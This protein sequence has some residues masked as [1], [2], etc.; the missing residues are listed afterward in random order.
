MKIQTTV[1]RPLCNK[2]GNKV[3]L[4]TKDSPKISIVIPTYNR[5][6]YLSQAIKSALDQR[7]VYSN[8]E[9]LVID[10]GST[11]NTKNIVQNFQNKR[12]RYIYKEHS[13]CPNTR[14]FA[15]NNAYGDYILWLDSDD[16]ILPGIL[17][18]YVQFV[19]SFPEVDIFYPDLYITDANL[20]I[21]KELKYQD[22]YNRNDEL[23]AKLLFG[24]HVPNGG[25]IIKK[26]L[27]ERIGNFDESFVRAHDY[28]FY[29]RAVG[30]AKF[31]KFDQFVYKWRW[32]DSNMSS[33]TVNYDTVYEALVSVNM[34][35]IYE[36]KLL[37]PTLP[38]GNK[39]MKECHSEAYYQVALRLLRL[40]Q[41]V[42]SL[43]Y[44]EKSLELNKSPKSVLLREKLNNMFPVEQ[45]DR[46]YFTVIIPTFNR[47]KTLHSSIQSVLDQN[48]PNFEII[49]V[50]D[51]GKDVQPIIDSFKRNKQITYIS[52]EINKGISAARNTGI[53]AARGEYI[54]LLDDDD[55]FYPEHLKTA[56]RHL[57]KQTPVIYT[58]A[59]RAVQKKINGNYKII[60]QSIPYSIE[61]DRHKLLIGN[62]APVN[63]F[64][65]NRMLALKAGLFDTS[66][67]SLEDWEFWI[68]LSH[69]CDFKH[70][71]VPTVQVNWRTDGTTITSSLNNSF[72][73]NRRILYNRY[74]NIIKR[75][76]N[77][78]GIL[79]EFNKI[80][81]N[82]PIATSNGEKGLVSIVILTFNQLRYTK[83]CIRSIQKYTSEKHEI[84]FVDNGSTDGTVKW[85]RSQSKK[86]SNYKL[87]LNDTNNGF[88]KGCN[89]GIRASTG[90]YILLLNN[91]VVVTENW[92]SGMIEC[93]NFR[94]DVGIV[95]PMTNN[96][97]GPQKVP[98]VSY[99]SIQDLP[100]FA[101]SFNERNRYRR[102][103]HQRIVG[104]CMLF[105]RKLVDDI[106]YLDESFGTGNFEDD[107]FCL[108]S[109]LHGYQNYIAGDVFIHHYGSRSFIGNKIEYSGLLDSNKNIFLDKWN[110][111][112]RNDPMFRN[113]YI[114]NT[115]QKANE[116][117]HKGLLDKCI[118]LLLDGLK[119]FADSKEIAYHLINFLKENNRFEEACNLIEALPDKNSDP[120][121]YILKGY[122]LEGLE[123][124]NEAGAIAERLSSIENF[125]PQALNLKGIMAYK[126]GDHKAA[127]LLFNE[128]IA[129][130][131]SYDEPYAN[132]G[133]L[134]WESGKHDD[135]LSLFERS[136]ILSPTTSNNATN[137]HTAA[138]ACGAIDSA[139]N[140]F[141]EANALFPISK[142][143]KFLHIDLLV[144]TGQFARAMDEIESSML[145]F[146]IDDG[147]LKAGLEIRRKIGPHFITKKLNVKTSISLC[148]IVKN[149]EHY[150]ARCL[151]NLKPL[152]DELIVVDTGSDDSTRDIAE[153]FGAK[154]FDYEWQD[155]FAAARNF[156]LKKASGG[157]IL[158]MD[159][160]EVIAASDH[161][162]ILDLIKKSKNNK[163]AYVLT[164][165]NYTD[166]QDSAG[167]SENT[168][169]YKEEMS[170]GWIPS[171]KVR[172]FQNQKG[173][174][175]VFP[176]HEQVDPVLSDMGISLVESPIPV[177]HYGKL[178]QA[179]T[180]ER[181]QTYYDIG[182][183]KLASQPDNDHALKEL[184]IQAGLLS[185]WE[186]AATLW[187]SFIDRNP[188]SVDGYLNI[189]RVMANCGDY[190]QANRYA[191]KA[192]QIAGD[193]SE[194]IYN[195]VLSE[196]Q[197]GQAAKAAK[198]ANRM[199]GTFPDDPD[200]KL[201]YALAEICA[202]KI[203][204]GTK[205]LCKLSEIVP[206]A[207]L[208]PR[209]RS[210]LGSIK[211]AGFD[212][213]VISL[214]AELSKM[215]HFKDMA[216]QSKTPLVNKAG[217]TKKTTLASDENTSILFEKAVR[218]YEREN[219]QAAIDSIMNI[220]AAESDHWRSYELLVDVM[221]Q[222]DQGIDIPNQLRA[223]ENRS[224]L[225]ARMMALIGQGYEVSG[226]LEKATDFAAQALNIDAECAR[227]W[228]LKGVI[229][230]R[231]GHDSEASQ[232][233]Q[234]ASECDKNW[235]DPWTNMGTLHWDHRDQDKALD[236]FETGFQ[237]SPTGPNVATTYHI[238]ISETGQYERAR[239]LFEQAI[240]HH[241]NFRKGRFLLID[242][243]IRMEAYQEA[244]DHI[245]TVLVQF[246]ADPQFL[247]A[248]KT[249]RDKVGPMTVEKGKQPSLSVCMIVKNEEKYLPGCL[250]S[251]KPIADEMIIIDTGSEDATRDIAEIFGAR[252]FDYEWQ[253]DFSAA[254]NHSLK[255][256][257]GDWI[258][259]MDADE[260][261]APS[262]HEILRSLI[263]KH[264]DENI[265]FLMTARNYTSI[266]NGVGWFANDGAY[267]AFET[268]C[269]W[270]PSTKTRLFKRSPQIR[271]EYPVH[272]LV[273]PSLD[274]TG[275][276]IT[277]CDVPVHHY[278]CLH[279]AHASKKSLQYNAIAQD[280]LTEMDNDPKVLKELAIRASILGEYEEAID[281]WH[282]LARIQPKNPNVHINLSAIYDKLGRFREAKLAAR[283]ATMVAPK[284]KEGYLNLGRSELLLGNYTAA[285]KAFKKILSM[286]KSFHSAI[287]LLGSAQIC[288]GKA[289]V[290][291]TTISQLRKMAI[292]H[293]LP[294]AF[295]ELATNLANA[296]FSIKAQ[297][298]TDCVA[299]L[300]DDVSPID[301]FQ[302]EGNESSV[303][304]PNV[305][306]K[307]S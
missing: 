258:L 271:F 241:P 264:H 39:S 158:V 136:F 247:E 137:Y 250:E 224:D 239:P 298:L 139:T 79:Q 144:K 125:R 15:I 51:A 301:N 269:G 193:R 13:G 230:Y 223:L 33:E 213:W 96:I 5:G 260:R 161:G 154:V 108:R 99:E 10:D 222:S 150:L 233:F 40:N 165:R 76:P 142:Q 84:I 121:K 272:E 153:V 32:H 106:G 97:S 220:V 48:F 46:Y 226:N 274:R 21:K 75:I 208:L 266:F 120:E 187:K 232:F 29:S 210:I 130:D 211:S 109:V 65:F 68:K 285:I 44:I 23:T 112:N 124:L 123:K 116:L 101:K 252:V 22:W 198:T 278:G 118:K 57:N 304:F 67:S 202:G 209:I 30:Q 73:E 234:K 119:L 59:V 41:P 151:N 156:S 60:G 148:M 267:D 191:D 276:A 114:V 221:L 196:L 141:Y 195:L 299:T 169:Q 138:I 175:F 244:L 64:V 157:W 128:S 70:V 81:S 289:D 268:G 43:K 38:W 259:V 58:D 218:Y 186:E 85:L 95:G 87:I 16:A 237:L 204:E 240:K 170:T 215:V 256:A 63:C 145:F 235:G 206:I 86:Y 227:A 286:E 9:V 282:R 159:A 303:N 228:N 261:I 201:L 292:W 147:I 293:S 192:F 134:N 181:W 251:L 255:K 127:E 300:F 243:L 62:I 173:V 61:Y 129:A 27:Y 105:K 69:Y 277:Q 35:N 177:H 14:N 52:H 287:F 100:S 257:S 155:D 238:A 50:N 55:I 6:R 279:S 163:H 3:I 245:E 56:F 72:R 180:A 160:D 26:S 167:Y 133:I 104:F 4:D 12:V 190:E 283:K 135:A 49:V 122:C 194:T 296:G 2:R 8:F 262:D 88:S 189:T 270:I 182:H 47:P 203:D 248:A 94:P 212:E 107:D 216:V 126:Q 20:S 152:V 249:I 34:L 66:L 28:E 280:K 231:N 53:L 291:L 205:L 295:K 24:N 113:L 207:S 42:L 82:D 74:K 263:D 225:S 11:D 111:I 31:K 98:Q 78:N 197:T 302:A 143:I 132:L 236:C 179:R 37:F 7:K 174:H 25:S 162:K 253:G 45:K 18:K 294:H 185:K 281:L 103:R 89:Q 214:N 273:D 305:L 171:K 131:P 117:F 172:L 146:G 200:G 140:L 229:A 17:L 219:Y 92:L 36:L 149:E 164:T 71:N 184:A 115:I 80:W 242:I 290:G 297:Q 166:R 102:I 110:S 77:P 306:S 307:A 93:L 176:V 1:D 90:E 199:V 168:G 188:D 284:I 265:A 183:K 246:G 217:V 19:I 254:R 83:E 288:N 91:D 54:A 275:C 178:D